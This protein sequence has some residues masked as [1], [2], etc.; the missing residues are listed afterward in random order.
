MSPVLKLWYYHNWL[1]D[2][3]EE[4]EKLKHLGYLIGS[5]I[6]PERVK[7]LL[8]DKGKH[9]STDEEYEESIN[10]VRNYKKDSIKRDRHRIKPKGE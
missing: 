10:M 3:E 6:S 1:A 7:D 4:A 8:D 2:K 9:L 5:F